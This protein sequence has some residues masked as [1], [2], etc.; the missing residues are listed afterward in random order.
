MNLPVIIRPGE[1]PIDVQTVMLL[2][3]EL[4]HDVG[5]K[6]GTLA[7]VKAARVHAAE[8]QKL[9]ALLNA[10][11]PAERQAAIELAAQKLAD[12]KLQA[13]DLAAAALE[14]DAKTDFHGSARKVVARAV[15]LAS[16][17]AYS[18]LRTADWVSILRPG[19]ASAVKRSPSAAP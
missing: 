17:M 3:A 9:Q 14:I 15:E 10:M 18:E 12:G 11:V 16:N 7:P 4:E 13:G 1:S 2:L 19:V 5:L 6:L 8:A